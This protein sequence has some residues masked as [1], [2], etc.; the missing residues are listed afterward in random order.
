MT[1][2][3][4]RKATTLSAHHVVAFVRGSEATTIASAVMPS[5]QGM[6]GG[7]VPVARGEWLDVLIGDPISSEEVQLSELWSE[8][9]VTLLERVVS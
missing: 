6:A 1:L 7:P 2:D 9:P 3:A 8:G 5:Y 4:A